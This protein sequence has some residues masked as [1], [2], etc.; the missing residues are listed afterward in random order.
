MMNM[1]GMDMTTADP[2]AGHNMDH[3]GMDHSNMDHS[4][5]DHSNHQLH[6]N[7]DV[8]GHDGMM[9]NISYRLQLLNN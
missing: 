2:H 5:M 7:G 9:V 8:S 4:N 1:S 6:S 3:G